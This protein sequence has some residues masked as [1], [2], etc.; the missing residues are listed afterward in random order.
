MKIDFDGTLAD[1]Q[2]LVGTNTM[3]V[4]PKWAKLLA[5]DFGPLTVVADGVELGKIEVVGVVFGSFEKTF[6]AQIGANH[7]VTA[8]G[9]PDDV[10]DTLKRL[11]GEDVYDKLLVAIYFGDVVA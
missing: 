8:G 4:G 11:Y 3:R 6:A 7:G 1:I 2:D 10:L 9:T 5:D